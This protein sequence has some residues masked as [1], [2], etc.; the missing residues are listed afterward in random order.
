MIELD[1]IDDNKNNN[2]FYLERY[3]HQLIMINNQDI[4]EG[5]V[6][7]DHRFFVNYIKSIFVNLASC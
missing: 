2:D 4:F 1:I 5:G 3:F 7:I 6:K